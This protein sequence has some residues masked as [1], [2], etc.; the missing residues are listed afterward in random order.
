MPANLKVLRGKR[1]ISLVG[2]I[3]VFTTFIAKEIVRENLKDRISDISMAQNVFLIRS[4]HTDS[5]S[6]MGRLFSFTISQMYEQNPT[7]KDLEEDSEKGNDSEY[8]KRWNMAFPEIEEFQKELDNLKHLQE[9]IPEG[10]KDSRNQFKEV[11]GSYQ[12][13]DEDFFTKCPK[14]VT[15]LMLYRKRFGR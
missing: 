3:I 6:S 5:F 9:F 1:I 8:Q 2:L 10:D 4:D 11:D 7:Y 13:L 14:C 15:I 12:R